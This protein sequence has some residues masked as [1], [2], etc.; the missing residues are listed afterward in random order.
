[1]RVLALTALAACHSATPATWPVP[2]GWKHELIPFP[3]EFAP[4]LP[5]RGVEELRFPPG[6]LDD[7]AANRW[8]Y[9]FVW[10]LEDPAML[11]APALAGELVLY[12]RGLL[13]AVDGDKHR[14]DPEQITAAA[15]P[16]DS[17]FALTAHV[18]DTFHAAGPVDLVG[19]ARRTPCG[20]GSLWTFV[21]APAS[22]PIRAT[23]DGLAASA[24]CGQQAMK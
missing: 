7:A 8:S 21:L 13:A 2:A 18:I 1:M 10:R 6:F 4:Q 23:L 22:S 20:P 9:T 17:G 24:E 12:F 3:L 16:S 5:H 14:L 15:T 19:T 11:D